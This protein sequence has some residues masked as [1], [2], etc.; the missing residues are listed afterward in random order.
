[1]K[2]SNPIIVLKY[3]T[4][5]AKIIRTVRFFNVLKEDSEVSKASFI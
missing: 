3:I 5:V 1:M 4:V 2:G